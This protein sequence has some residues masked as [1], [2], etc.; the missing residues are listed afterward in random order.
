MELIK[1]RIGIGCRGDAE[2]VIAS[3]ARFSEK[4]GGT[5]VCYADKTT[6]SG[7][8][9]SGCE[10][11]LSEHPAEEMIDDLFCGK[12]DAAV[13]G[14]LPAGSTLA[15]LKKRYSVPYLR[16]IALLESPAGQKFFFAPVG[17]DEGWTVED[18]EAFVYEG[19]RY[20]KAC[21]LPEKTVVLAGG[22]EGDVGR[23]PAVDK[24]IEDALEVCRRTGA[25]FGEILIEDA[26]SDAGVVIA[27]DGISGNLV[28]RTLALLGNGAGHGAPVVNIPDVYVDSSRAS[29]AYDAVL[30]FTARLVALK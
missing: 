15:Y 14:S 13:R 30:S 28:F 10:F 11:I 7:A 18:K 19:R 4:S 17:V 8:K 16:R 22:R 21:G 25:V 5:V 20:A 9:A 26:V 23:H 3:A 12:I 27:P 24:S 6:C 1:M 29:E 2:K